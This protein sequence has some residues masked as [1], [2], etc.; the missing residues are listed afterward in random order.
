MV[1]ASQFLST[2]EG[3]VT[4]CWQDIA[5]Q[6]E[7]LSQPMFAC[8]AMTP[9]GGATPTFLRRGPEAAPLGHNLHLFLAGGGLQLLQVNVIPALQLFVQVLKQDTRILCKSASHGCSCACAVPL[10]TQCLT[11]AIPSI[12]LPLRLQHPDE[13]LSSVSGWLCASLEGPPPLHRAFQ[14]QRTLHN[15]TELHCASQGGPTTAL[16]R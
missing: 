8:P 5:S 11:A 16:R 3:K 12:E 6:E 10:T 4:V 1:Q 7:S 13:V 14:L 9:S 15:T 2:T